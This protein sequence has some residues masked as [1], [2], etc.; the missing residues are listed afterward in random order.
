MSN[1]SNKKQVE[2]EDLELISELLSHSVREALEAA[3]T[4]VTG[5]TL[6]TSQ[7]PAETQTSITAAQEARV[8]SQHDLLRRATLG[9]LVAG[10][11]HQSRNIMTGVL[12]FAQIACHRNTDPKLETLLDNIHKE[13]NRCV[14]L[15]NQILTLA[16]SREVYSNAV[17]SRVLLA[18]TISSAC[19]LSEPA[20]KEREIRLENTV[21]GTDLEISGDNNALRDLF[22]NLLRNAADATP[23]GGSIRVSAESG[24][25]TV[26]ICFED[27][28]TGIPIA[29]RESVFEP[30]FT[31]KGAGKGTGLGL[32]VSKQVVLEHRGKIVV[33]ES[34]LGGARFL[35]TFPKASEEDDAA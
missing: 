19:G 30:S 27:S 15:M 16:R 35:I 10:I 17:Y 4:R 24:D 1:S 14:D 9:D 21:S 18:E 29:N 8:E 7:T 26:T 2:L 11:T 6:Q 32:A 12:S 23:D 31:T 28:G 20:M 5:V 22:I 33:D 25:D 13:S 3:G 34:P